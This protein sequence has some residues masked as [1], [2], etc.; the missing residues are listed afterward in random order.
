MHP[1]RPARSSRC[2]HRERE[3]LAA[4]RPSR[5]DGQAGL[6]LDLYLARH[7]ETEWTLN[8]RHTGRTDLPLTANGEAEA[9]A[10]RTRLAG[11]EFDAVF[12]SPLQRAIRTAVIAG[13]P[14]PRQT[15]LLREFD[16]GEY[17]GA[18]SQ[19]I[20]ARN[21]GWELF[22]DGCPG[23]ETP[24]Q[25]NARAEEFIRLCEE[26]SGRILAFAHGHILRAVAVAWLRLDITT[27]AGFELDVATV[28]RLRDDS[29][30][31]RLI[32]M[33]NSP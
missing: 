2:G 13:F 17:E 4:L 33:W 20:H 10:L 18:T 22:R 23:G 32:A 9:R 21:P 8:G 27:A 24:A 28:S 29:E 11:I 31:G 14:D 26:V 5:D 6:T 3:P 30:R 15:P 12:S 7:G 25:V 1:P 16:Y 19:E